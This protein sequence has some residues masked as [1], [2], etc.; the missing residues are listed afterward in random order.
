MPSRTEVHKNL[1][2]FHK[3][4]MNIMI[5]YMGR[6][7]ISLMTQDIFMQLVWNFQEV[8]KK[9]YFTFCLAGVAQAWGGLGMGL[10][11]LYWMLLSFHGF[12]KIA[13]V[14]LL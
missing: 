10:D 1:K 13:C 12:L 4:T 8:Y 14:G 6:N 2:K 7:S 11:G 3:Q 9:I 5:F